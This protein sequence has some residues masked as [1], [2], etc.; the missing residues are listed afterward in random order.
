MG[1]TKYPVLD[2]SFY[3][4]MIASCTNDEQRGLITVLDLTGMHVS[5][6][7]KLGPDSMIRQGDKIYLK[8][9]RP[10]NKKTLQSEVPPIKVHVIQNFLNM[11]RKT[12][13]FYFILVKEIGRTAG[14]QDVSPM[15]FRHNRAI[16][17]L[18]TERY[19]IYELPQIMGCTLEVAVRNYAKVKEA[20]LIKTQREQE[21]R[22]QSNGKPRTRTKG[23]GMVSKLMRRR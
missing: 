23:K 7:C 17:A 8:W 18:V 21:Q 15:T 1:A 20:D 16:R 11:R 13:E 12:R 2:E 19:T 10:K 9:V 5:S 22:A 6:V 3:P 4:R 14:Y